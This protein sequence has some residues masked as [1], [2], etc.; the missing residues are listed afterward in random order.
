M[1]K[2]VELLITYLQGHLSKHG[3]IADF[4]RKTN[5]SRP[6]VD[7]WFK[8]ERTPDLEALTKAAKYFGIQPW[9]LL[10]PEGAIPT[11]APQSPTVEAL[12]KVIADQERRIKELEAQLQKNGEKLQKNIPAEQPQELP[13]KDELFFRLIDLW[14][15]LDDA[16]RGSVVNI[17]SELVK[18]NDELSDPVPKPDK[19][20]A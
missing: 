10:Q 19:A 15:K 3:D 17:A 18:L 2:T 7:R 13:V 4:C 20:G 1:D 14:D 16:E 9:E 5:I 8:G 11:P 12:T 6:T